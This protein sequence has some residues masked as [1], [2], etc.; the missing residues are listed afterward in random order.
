MSTFAVN[1]E[2]IGD[3]SN[4]KASWFR[5]DLRHL[6]NCP[7]HWKTFHTAP[8]PDG[9]TC[10]PKICRRLRFVFR[11]LRDIQLRRE[12]C[13]PQSSKFLVLWTLQMCLRHCLWRW[14]LWIS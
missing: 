9:R 14:H 3:G 12:S 8:V 4:R 11:L 10:P 2:N 13:L 5:G 6:Y 1:D 7:A